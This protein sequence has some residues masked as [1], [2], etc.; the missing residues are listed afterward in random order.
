[1]NHA[2][3]NEEPVELWHVEV[4]PND[5]R[6]VTLEQLDEAFQQG[7]VNERTRVFQDGMDEPAFLGELLGLG[8]DGDEEEEER[9][10]AAPP[11]SAAVSRNHQN[12]LVGLPADPPQH[13]PAR[14][15][16]PPQ[17]S[18]RPVQ[19]APAPAAPQSYRPVQSAPPPA[20]PQSYRPV[21]SA[22]PPMTAQTYRQVQSIP[23]QSRRAPAT[24][25]AWPPVVARPSAAPAPSVVA[26]SVV[27][28]A[29]DLNDIGDID[30]PRP[31]RTGKVLLLG[32]GAL[33][34]AAGV[35]LAVTGKGPSLLN[36]L[37]ASNTASMAAMPVKKAPAPVEA[38]KSHG[39]D[40]G[41]APIKLKDA[42]PPLVLTTRENEATVLA[43]AAG[44]AP[45]ATPA[46]DTALTKSSSKK[47]AATK[48]VASKRAKSGGA[49][50]SGGGGASKQRGGSG[51]LKGGGGV[52]DPLN[53]QL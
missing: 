10:E 2:L 34:V 21:Q 14:S 20:G 37:T 8:D 27:P 9:V 1:M 47:T 25:S 32:V 6:I 49:P 17:A 46:A 16:P 5:V 23:P 50:K 30:F 31:K 22:P 42:P 52:Y 40:V 33:A 48:A 36:S 24:E 7:L 11:P 39:L 18:H 29:L 26:P 38:P 19:S 13:S 45:A 35:A 15:A 43:A 12:T 3:Q 53:G 4:G 41:D 44:T 51:S 28:M